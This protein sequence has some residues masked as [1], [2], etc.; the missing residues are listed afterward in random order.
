MH[1]LQDLAS[2]ISWVNSLRFL[3]AHC[4]ALL[5]YK[6]TEKQRP[7]SSSV[8]LHLFR[9]GVPLAAALPLEHGPL[10]VRELRFEQCARVR[11]R[12]PL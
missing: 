1:A 7:L 8:Y 3:R 12:T 2:R 11:A 10:D 6:G 5:T 9:S 4:P